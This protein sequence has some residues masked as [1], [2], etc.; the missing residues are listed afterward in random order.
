MAKL[1]KITTTE[2]KVLFFNPD[3]VCLITPPQRHYAYATITLQDSE[4]IE[5]SDQ[6]WARIEPLLTGEPAPQENDEA[7][8]ALSFRATWESIEDLM[9]SPEMKALVQ[10]GKRIDAIHLYRFTCNNFKEAKAIVNV[11]MEY[12][13][14]V[15]PIAPTLPESVIDAMREYREAQKYD[16]GGMSVGRL[17]NILNVIEKLMPQDS[18]AQS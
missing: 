5:V 18:E 13:S 11:A 6:E 10:A 3:T 9:R 17:Q 2:D 14:T 7:S 4:E 15:A 16:P 1:I 8:S 12:A